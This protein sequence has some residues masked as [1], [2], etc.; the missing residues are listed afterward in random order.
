A[1]NPGNPVRELPVTLVIC[2]RG[3]IFFDWVSRWAGCIM[4][5]SV[6]SGRGPECVNTRFLPRESAMA[7]PA[8]DSDTSEPT[9]QRELQDSQFHDDDQEI[10]ADDVPRG[11]GEAPRLP[12]KKTPVKKPMPRRRFEDD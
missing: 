2:W 6:A 1:R 8:A 3:E 4:T 9:R 11:H 5:I 12:I 7:N 10:A